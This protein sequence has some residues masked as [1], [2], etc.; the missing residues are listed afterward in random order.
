MFHIFGK[1]LFLIDYLENFIDIHNHILPG[2]DDGA[3]TP[4]DSMDLIQGFAQFGVS[5]FIATPHIMHN[6]YPNTP[7]SINQALSLVR[8]ELLMANMKDVA[9]AASAEHMID[10]NY[11]TILHHDD[12]M[13]MRSDYLLVEMSYLQPPLNFDT[14]IIKTVSKRYYPILAHPE[15]YNFLHFKTKKYGKYKEQ[16]ILFQMNLLS[17][18]DF[19]GKEV[20]KIAHKLL[21]EGLIDFVASDVHNLNQL[22]S[23]KN[24]TVSKKVVRKL[25]P[26]INKTIETFY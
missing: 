13:P 3:K 23:L 10:D 21:D 18:G 6:Y 4:K 14:A 16:G 11:E 26:I 20:P 25:L 5:N 17:L 24:Q 15:R 7:Q 1:K 8:N 2:I 22:N 9:I 12:V 19:Y